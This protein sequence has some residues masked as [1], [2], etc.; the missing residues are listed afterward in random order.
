MFARRFPFLKTIHT[1]TGCQKPNT[2]GY[3]SVPGIFANP[4]KVVAF[5][6]SYRGFYAASQ[7]VFT[8]VLVNDTDYVYF[9]TINPLN[10]IVDFTQDFNIQYAIETKRPFY[11]SSKTYHMDKWIQLKNSG[12]NVTSSWITNDTPKELMSIE[13]KE[14]LCHAFIHDIKKSDFGVFYAE[15]DDTEMIGSLIEFGMLTALDKPIYIMGQNKFENEVF[16]HINSRVNYEYTD[17]YDVAQNILSIYMDNSPSY[18]DFLSRTQI[19]SPEKPIQVKPLDYVAIVA[20]GEGSRL[21]PLTR[22]I[23]KLLV[24]FQNYSILSHTIDYWKRYTN[25][26]IIVIQSKYNTLVKF[27]MD[28]L[29]VDY[30]IINVNVS[31]GYENSYTIHHAFKSPK[32]HGKRLLMTWCDIYPTSAIP[33]NVF[34]DKNV[35]FTYKNYGRYDAFNNKIMKKTFGNVIGIYY[36]SRFKNIE[37]FEPH[38]DICD[39]YLAHYN[40]FDTYEFQ[41]LV[42]IGDMNKLDYLITHDTGYKTRYFNSL[43]VTDH[44]TLVKRSTCPYGDRIIADEMRFY[45][46]H[47]SMICLPRIVSYTSNSFEMEKIADVTIHEHFKTI[48][49]EDQCQLLTDTL[50]VLHEFHSR[51]TVPAPKNQLFTDV[52][53]EFRKKINSRLDN[54]SSLLCEFNFIK[55]VNGI[56]IVH[57]IEHIKNDM[58]QR[59]KNYFM[60]KTHYQSIHGDPHMSNII[61]GGYLIDPRGYFGNTKLFGPAEYDIGKLVYSL[62][63]FDYFNSDDKFAFYIDGSN[64]TVDIVNN[65]DPF[66]HLFDNHKVLIYMT[67]LHW[68]GLADYTK[69]NIHKCV[70]AYYYGIYLYHRY[71]E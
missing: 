69:M 64:I 25:K 9:N 70:S 39:C 54:V 7:V 55:S 57:G 11:I 12:L 33:E 24:P 36:F 3:A 47:G 21:M 68:L 6:D 43:N 28:L 46:F 48:G 20:S 26:F 17:K 19:Q 59:I 51:H 56:T 22:H 16:Y 13:Q 29:H 60:N 67:I 37:I 62:S 34:S 63:G 31:K 66:I 40:Q 23:P 65:I 58:Y 49:Y 71:L 15:H 4:K 38:M 8:V 44:G 53:I 41:S 2:S 1:I 18:Q 32:F 5:E 30:E 50:G 35:I 27:Y 42:D 61:K 14:A 10:H 45:K 52:D